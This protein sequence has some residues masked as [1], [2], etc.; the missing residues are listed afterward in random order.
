ILLDEKREAEVRRDE[1]TKWLALPYWEAEAGLL[2]S[3]AVRDDEN[4]LLGKLVTAVI[5]VKRAQARIDQRIALLRH[6][7]ALRMYAADNDG[8][9][10]AK[11]DEVKVP[12]PVDPVTGKPFLYEV[13]GGTALIKG[14]A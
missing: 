6:V 7:E 4:A 3:T 5:K 8:K 13:S 10:P 12:L 14:S 1:R 2:D 9:L 11:L